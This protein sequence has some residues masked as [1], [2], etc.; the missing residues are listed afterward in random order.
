MMS[1]FFH[2][3]AALFPLLPIVHCQ[4]A[5]AYFLTPWSQLRISAGHVKGHVDGSALLRRRATSGLDVG[6]PSQ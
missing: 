2:G 3:N 4:I 5:V 6:H 1:R